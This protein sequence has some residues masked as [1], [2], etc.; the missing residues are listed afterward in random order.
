MTALLE[1]DLLSLEESFCTASVIA[2]GLLLKTLCS[3][4]LVARSPEFLTYRREDVLRHSSSADALLL[5]N[6]RPHFSQRFVLAIAWSN[7]PHHLTRTK[8]L[9]G[10][11]PGFAV[12]AF[13]ALTK[14]ANTSG[15]ASEV[16][17]VCIHIST[18]R[19]EGR[20]R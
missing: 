4:C 1:E 2:A 13:I 12:S 19:R 17:I 6:S 14:P 16:K 7:I 8:A 11:R 18:A 9:L 10:A 3:A 20:S 15:V 5:N